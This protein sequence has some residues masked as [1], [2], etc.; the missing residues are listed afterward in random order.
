VIL[1]ENLR[2]VIVS[3]KLSLVELREYPFSKGFLDCFKVYLRELG[4]DA[5]PPVSVSKEPVQVR[6]IV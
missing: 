4:E 6:M 2:Y 3:N 1:R 5:V